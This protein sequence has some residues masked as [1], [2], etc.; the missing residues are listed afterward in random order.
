MCIHIAHSHT[1]LLNPT[2]QAGYDT[3]SIKNEVQ[4]V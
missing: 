3:R 1:F 4:Q 2:L